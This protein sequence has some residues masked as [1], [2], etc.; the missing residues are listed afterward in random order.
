MAESFNKDVAVLAKKVYEL[1]TLSPEA[2][3]ERKW[4]ALVLLSAVYGSATPEGIAKANADKEARFGK[5]IQSEGLFASLHPKW[6]LRT[7]D[8]KPPVAQIALA[9]G[10]TNPHR[11][12]RARLAALM[13]VPENERPP[14]DD[15]VRAFVADAFAG[16]TGNAKSQYLDAV[17]KRAPDWFKKPWLTVTPYDGNLPPASILVENQ[18]E[19]HDGGI[20]DDPADDTIVEQ[21][22]NS[23]RTWDVNFLRD[24]PAAQLYLAVEKVAAAGAEGVGAVGKGLGSGFTGIASALKNLP[25]ILGGAA[26]T[27]LVV[28]LGIVVWS[29][30]D[31]SR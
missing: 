22:R 16:A 17:R 7:D 3:D 5:Q 13:H 15:V 6:H 19:T 24:N 31:D 12:L 26:A 1:T 8:G 11:D 4:E 18:G 21:W 30:R 28:G 2:L 14:L 29:D 20:Y 10:M 25:I 9:S 23:I 27:A